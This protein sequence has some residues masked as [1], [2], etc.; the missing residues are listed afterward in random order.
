MR[1][2]SCRGESA[3]FVHVECVAEFAERKDEESE[4][5]SFSFR[6]TCEQMFTGALQLELA[7]RSWRRHRDGK[8][9]SWARAVAC[10]TLGELL[11]IMDE[12][13]A[14]SML[15]ESMRNCP[16]FRGRRIELKTASRLAKSHSRN[17]TRK[18]E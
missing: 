10:H 16:H 18:K 5:I 9:E 14:E 2:C 12:N 11:G 3:G 7:R 13:D 15:F 6:M 8:L 4:G 17:L 1:G